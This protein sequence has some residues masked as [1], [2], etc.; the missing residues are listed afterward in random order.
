MA[1]SS[2]FSSPDDGGAQMRVIR[3]IGDQ[4]L[5]MSYPARRN[6]KSKL[7]VCPVRQV[8]QRV[9]DQPAGQQHDQNEDDRLPVSDR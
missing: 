4:L 2:V 3:G 1:T 5:G 9:V 8:L 6:R 7:S